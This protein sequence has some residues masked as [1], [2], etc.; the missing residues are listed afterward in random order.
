MA[1]FFRIRSEGGNFVNGLT[2]FVVCAMLVV[3]AGMVAEV[4]GASNSDARSEKWAEAAAR[5]AH[6]AQR[7]QREARLR[8]DNQCPTST[9]RQEAP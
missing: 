6:E 9:C 3:A 8:G 4:S 2:R 1:R 5:Q 7:R